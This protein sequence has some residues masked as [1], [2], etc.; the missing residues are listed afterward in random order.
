MTENNELINVTSNRDL[1]E[2]KVGE[3]QAQLQDFLTSLNLPHEK[4]LVSFI[5][6]KKV[7]NNIPTI[8]NSIS[9][10]DCKKSFYISKF[11]AACAS[12]LFDAALNYLWD[13]TINNLR[14]KITLFDLEYFKSTLEDEELKKKIKNIDDLKK[15]DDW[16][17]VRGCNNT[18][19]ITEIGF[20]H[21]DYIRNM[22]NHASAAHPN[23][24]EL[25][26]LQISSWLETCI[27][28]V[29]GKEPSIPAIHARHLLDNIRKNTLSTNDIKPIE[30]ALKSTPEEIVIS[31]FRTIFGIFVDPD[32]KVETK[33]NIRLIAKALWEVLPE[34]QK[35][36]TGI[37]N[38]NWAAN[39]DISRR[40]AS[41]E[42]LEIVNALSYLSSDT[43]NLEMHQAI[44]M[45]QN[46]HFSFNNFYNELPC[47]RLLKKY[48][49]ENG[50]IP[51][52]VRV[53]YV[54]TI[55]M[56]LIGNGRG[57][58]W[59]AS[60]IYN[61]L[62]DKF[63]EKEIKCFLALFKDSDFSSR[64]QFESC[65]NSYKNYLQIIR[66]RTSNE[67]V[68]KMLEHILAQTN[69]QLPLLGKTTEYNN[70]LKTIM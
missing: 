13:E 49:P 68:K 46:A 59:L 39:A 9:E 3:Y 25:T 31:I 47:A 6:R 12:G 14:L 1:L 36:E 11:I 17:L 52:A 4:I 53:E 24:V 29:I 62:F 56:C 64:M 65:K 69:E 10:S 55:T 61:E 18:G 7:I 28:E 43:I 45:L 37:K 33:N 16:E 30:D 20:K 42:F 67:F 5:E 26:G 70:I 54:K 50:N 57:V 8:V 35:K 51:D 23:H 44:K 22:R 27:I 58:S 40:D 21:L 66:D 2:T 63:T 60:P 19:I 41:R 32:S 34:E 15:I 48:V 38:A